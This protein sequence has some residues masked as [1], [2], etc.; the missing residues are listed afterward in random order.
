MLRHPLK[1]TQYYKTGNVKYVQGR[2]VPLSELDELLKSFG[3][4]G[5]DESILA[6]TD[7]HIWSQAS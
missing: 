7:M 4:A 5:G 3:E 2:N 1:V 6:N